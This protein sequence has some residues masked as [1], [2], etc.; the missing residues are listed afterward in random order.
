MIAVYVHGLM[1]KRYRDT[2]ENR[3]IARMFARMLEAKGYRDVV[4]LPM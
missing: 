4:I 1:F 3:T 2:R